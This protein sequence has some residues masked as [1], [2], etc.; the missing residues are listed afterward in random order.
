[1]P[2]KNKIDE[3]I[4]GPMFALA[5]RQYVSP[6]TKMLADTKMNRIAS[7]VWA[8]NKIFAAAERMQSIT[9][10]MAWAKN[11]GHIGWQRE[12]VGLNASTIGTITRRQSELQ[13]ALVGISRLSAKT[14]KFE[15]HRLNINTDM[16]R[17]NG[18]MTS[19]QLMNKRFAAIAGVGDIYGIGKLHHLS[20]DSLL[21]RWHTNLRLPKDY[22][23]DPEY[24]RSLYREAEVDEGLIETDPETAIEIGIASG[25]IV[26]EIIE[27]GQ[28]I[29]GKTASGLL[30]LSSSNLATDIFELVGTIERSLRD[31]ITRKLHDIAGTDWFKQ[32]VHAQAFEK[33]KETRAKALKAGESSAP[34]I[35]FLT[36]GELMQIVLRT[37][38]WEGAFKPIF[39]NRDW[40]KRDIEVIGVARNPN[41]H[42]RVNDSLRLTEALLVW[43][44]L[45]FYI[46]ND[47]QW[48]E[49]VQ[50][51]E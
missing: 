36:L 23:R 34:L 10:R 44:R 21:G 49:D 22:W 2:S 33:A 46:E 32:R 30:T 26:G 50:A 11:V 13:D 7:G 19:L 40:F 8:D 9:S 29:I 45:S 27:K 25:A 3:I 28:Y 20:V 41:A 39:R 1:M 38:N 43:Q 4:N 48:L 47:G 51:E 5:K 17:A 15:L 14:K 42:H 18:G 24:R 37:D 35:E 16:A 12:L 31:L 6:M